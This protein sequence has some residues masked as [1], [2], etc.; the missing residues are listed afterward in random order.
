M[1]GSD[2]VYDVLPDDQVVALAAMSAAAGKHT[3]AAAATGAAALVE[4]AASRWR[5]QPGS[6][7]V[8]AVVL[9]DLTLA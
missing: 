7:N 1:L 4:E 3:A 9:L 2:G 6:D 8:T 5:A